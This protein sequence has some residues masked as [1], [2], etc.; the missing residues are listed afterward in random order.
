MRQDIIRGGTSRILKYLRDKLKE[1]EM[2]LSPIVI[3][4]FAPDVS[5]FPNK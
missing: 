3:K 2:A 4:S 1:E 5:L